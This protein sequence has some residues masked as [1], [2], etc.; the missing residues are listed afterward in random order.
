MEATATSNRRR[1]RRIKTT[2]RGPRVTK[3]A[4]VL[5]KDCPD[6]CADV[7]HMKK[8]NPPGRQHDAHAGTSGGHALPQALPNLQPG[9]NV[10]VLWS[11][12]TEKH[13]QIVLLG[14]ER[15]LR[16]LKIDESG[17]VCSGRGL[18]G[19]REC[20]LRQT[21]RHRRGVVQVAADAQLLHT[22]NTEPAANGGTEVL[23]FKSG[24]LE[25]CLAALPVTPTLEEVKKI[26]TRLPCL[27]PQSDYDIQIVKGIPVY[28]NTFVLSTLHR[29]YEEKPGAYFSKLLAELVPAKVQRLPYITAAGKGSTKV[30]LPQTLMKALIVYIDQRT[31]GK[32]KPHNG[33]ANAVNSALTYERDRLHEEQGPSL[34]LDPPGPLSTLVAAHTS[35]LTVVRTGP[36]VAEVSATPSNSATPTSAT[37]TITSAPPS[38]LST[39]S[40]PSSRNNSFP[41]VDSFHHSPSNDT[42]PFNHF[43]RT[44]PPTTTFPTPSTNAQPVTWAP[45]PRHAR[46]QLQPLPPGTESYPQ[47]NDTNFLSQHMQN[48]DDDDEQDIY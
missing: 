38:I 39:P 28:V 3:F 43:P 41:I 40:I 23:P 26:V 8:I 14:A 37:P 15:T 4:I 22:V 48:F 35:A 33:F 19:R 17:K 18:L 10:T 20:E 32:Y 21:I 1:G 42:D 6:P 30:G 25:A 12:D 47:L 9:M 27:A 5:W 16:K 46:P 29:R 24:E 44:I 13:G 7:V 36:P 34:V 2:P 45:L 31:N 11:K